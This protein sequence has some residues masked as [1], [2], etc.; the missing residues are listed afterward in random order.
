MLYVFKGE[1][2]EKMLLYIRMLKEKTDLT[3]CASL[4]CISGNQA[5]RLKDAGLTRLHNNLETSR[6]YFPEIC[7][8]HTYDDKIKTI[9]SGLDAGLE[10]CCGGIFGMG[11][12]IE[13]RI[14]M[15]FEIR[16]LGIKNIPINILDPI[17]GTPLEHIEPVK[18]V[19]VLRSMALYRFI[20]P[21]SLI[22]YAGGRMNLGESQK[23]GFKGGVNAVMV[24]NYLTTVG[25][26]VEEDL[27]M[28]KDLG[29]E[30]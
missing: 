23:K 5:A 14:S 9:R 21:D 19:E 1:D 2:F 7:D 16:D 3:L 30:V 24:G 29:F 6:A 25:S 18:P 15:A 17:K 12:N 4:G 28:L 10:I 11:E 27:E 22:R 13:D 20:N 26:K 8:T